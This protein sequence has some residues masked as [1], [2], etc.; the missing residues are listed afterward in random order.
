M[1]EIV[2][3][4]LCV[5]YAAKY[6]SVAKF[7]STS[8]KSP[9]DAARC[10]NGIVVRLNHPLAEML[11]GWPGHPPA[12]PIHCSEPPAPSHGYVVDTCRSIRIGGN[13]KSKASSSLSQ[14]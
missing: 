11:D 12:I 5:R 3:A 8:A 1:L 9:I 4:D 13:D 6:S 10:L 2:R 14:P 7:Q